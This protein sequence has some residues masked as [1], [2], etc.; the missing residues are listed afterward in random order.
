[1]KKSRCGKGFYWECLPGCTECCC[2]TGGGVWVSKADVERMAM[3]M[4]MPV[5]DFIALYI[6]CD[7]GRMHIPTRY[8]SRCPFLQEGKGCSIYEARPTQCRTFPFWPEYVQSEAGWKEA[9]A[10]CPG[11]GNGRK[12]SIEEVA[13]CVH[14]TTLVRLE[15]IVKG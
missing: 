15:G 14:E 5:K 7:G 8:G 1:M 10:R 2:A 3:S 4:L 6:K 12:H 13:R 11:C 9:M